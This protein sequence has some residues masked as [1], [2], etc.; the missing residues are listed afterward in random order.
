ML[1]IEE[2]IARSEHF[3]K[4]CEQAG[5]S[6]WQEECEQLVAWLRELQERRKAPEIVRCGECEHFRKEHDGEM[7]CGISKGHGIDKDFFCRDAER[8]TE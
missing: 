1:T 2:K 7:W 5:M 3:A 8:R 4:L 6:E